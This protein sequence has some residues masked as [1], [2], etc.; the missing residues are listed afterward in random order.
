MS[1]PT[2]R[3]FKKGVEKFDPLFLREQYDNFCSL[4]D[5]YSRLKL[6]FM[7]FF[8]I[9]EVRR[10]FELSTIFLIRVW[11]SLLHGIFDLYDTPSLNQHP[12]LDLRINS[13]L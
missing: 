1:R 7:I 5:I 3:F 11:A 13:R 4:I 2:A 8:L 10:T 6:S 9:L 12:Q